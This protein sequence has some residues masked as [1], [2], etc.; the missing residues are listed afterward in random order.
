N[1]I[2]EWVDRCIRGTLSLEDRAALMKWLETSPENAEQFRKI[3]QAKI[4][5]SVAGK[6][7]QLD[8]MQERVWEHIIPVLEDRK[9]QWYSWGMRVAAIIVMMIGVLFWR[10]GKSFGKIC[11]SCELLQVESG[12]PKAIR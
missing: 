12:S 3:F 2:D 9:R 5:V 1:K 11:S 8:Q 6:W 7:R 10:L 4:R